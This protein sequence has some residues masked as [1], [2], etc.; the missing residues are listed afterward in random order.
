TRNLVKALDTL[1][2]AYEDGTRDEATAG[3]LRDM[4]RRL[5]KLMREESA[6]SESASER[7]LRRADET[8]V[9]ELED[10]V[11]WLSDLIGRARL[12]NAEH[13]LERLAAT[14]ARMRDLLKQLQKSQDP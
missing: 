9:A 11:L 12:S 14:R 2:N 7:E 8:S 3:L 6:A 4:A 13:S 5:S 10:D 1:A